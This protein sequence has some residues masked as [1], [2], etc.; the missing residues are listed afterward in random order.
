[1]S[2]A[3]AVDDA[4]G[5][6]TEARRRRLEKLRW[7]LRVARRAVAAKR[8]ERFS[9]GPVAPARGL[10]RA[11][12]TGFVTGTAVASLLVFTVNHFVFR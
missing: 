2:L 7:Q 10:D 4:V 5:S 6:M 3:F 11:V 9:L 8:K 1:M 12:V